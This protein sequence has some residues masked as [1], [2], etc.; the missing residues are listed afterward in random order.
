MSMRF[1]R[2]LSHFAALS[3]DDVQ[4]INRLGELRLRLYEPRETIIAE[5]E[6]PEVINLHL[7]GWAYRHTVL[8]NGKRQITSVLIP[9]DLCDFNMFVLDKMDHSVTAL[10]SVAIARITRP[11]FEAVIA[12]RPRLTQALWRETLVN[13]AIQRERTTT[14][15]QRDAVERISHTLCELFIRL[16]CVGLTNGNSC[17]MPLSQAEIGEI[18]GLTTV[19]VNRVLQDFRRS[20]LITLKHRTLTIV[21]FD[22]LKRRAM[23]NP[24]Y[25]HLGE[26]GGFSSIDS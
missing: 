22:E 9:G 15:G 2:K 18:T 10:T 14:L 23:F 26:A 3:N 4:A 24:N 16:D 20:N 19:S 5:G 1:V 12:E 11:D 6:R 13:A 21:D 17:P 7:D 8:A 25:L